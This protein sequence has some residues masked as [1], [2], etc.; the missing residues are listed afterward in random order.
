MRVY[1]KEVSCGESSMT[2]QMAEA[3][4]NKVAGY[5]AKTAAVLAEERSVDANVAEERSL[6]ED[7]ATLCTVFVSVRGM[8]MS[9]CVEHIKKNLPKCSGVY[10]ACMRMKSKAISC[11]KIQKRWAV[12]SCKKLTRYEA[13]TAGEERSVDINVAAERSLDED[14]A[15]VCA[16]VSAAKGMPLSD[17]KKRVAKKVASNSC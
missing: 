1:S 16:V 10:G 15:T 2:K 8:P 13:G 17:C 4:Y 5:G 3:E 12:R 14:I 7:I 9:D 11:G 6:D